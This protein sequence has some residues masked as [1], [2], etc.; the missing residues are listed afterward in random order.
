[1]KIHQS[2][3][4]LVERIANVLRNGRERTAQQIADVLGMNKSGILQCLGKH[5]QFEKV[6]GGW[7]QVFWRMK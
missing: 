2:S 7:N 4:P 1:M 6:A 5:D 3:V